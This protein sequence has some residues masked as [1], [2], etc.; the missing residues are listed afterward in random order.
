MDGMNESDDDDYEEAS[1]VGHQQKLRLRI[2]LQLVK[3]MAASKRRVVSG[4]TDS[5]FSFVFFCFLLFW[6]GLFWA[7][8][9]C[10]VFC[11]ISLSPLVFSS[12]NFCAC[13]RAYTCFFAS[14][15]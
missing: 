1:S 2:L 7:G 9:S 6:A 12:L 10:F 11:P 3:N 4:E 14:R 5:L 8:L 15:S 13:V